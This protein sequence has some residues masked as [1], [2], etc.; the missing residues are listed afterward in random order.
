LGLTFQREVVILDN[1]SVEVARNVRT[2][3]E[4]YAALIARDMTRMLATL[5]EE[6]CINEAVGV[7]WG[8]EWHGHDGLRAMFRKMSPD[9]E[10][11]DHTLGEAITWNSDASVVI[12]VNRIGFASKKTGREARGILSFEMFRFREGKII[13]IAPRFDRDA[14]TAIDGEF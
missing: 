14:V 6:I 8:G 13:E 7:P 9:Y 10:P 4:F 5:D 2:V 1:E 3:E 11:I 12:A